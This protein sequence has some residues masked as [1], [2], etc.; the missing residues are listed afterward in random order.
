MEKRSSIKETPS[1]EPFSVPILLATPS[2][3]LSLEGHVSVE[4]QAQ[5]LNEARLIQ[6]RELSKGLN[7][8]LDWKLL[9]PTFRQ[10]R[11]G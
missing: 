9:V 1:S 2:P 6:H 4:E 5:L 3:L 7:E 11:Y 8:A 10:A